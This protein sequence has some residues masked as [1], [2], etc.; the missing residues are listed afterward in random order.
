LSQ[1]IECGC[2]DGTVAT[3]KDFGAGITGELPLVFQVDACL[4]IQKAK[5]RDVHRRAPRAGA[6]GGL[7]QGQM[8]NWPTLDDDCGGR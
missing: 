5:L 3:V 7:E 4:A 8:G 1:P 2:L 6:R